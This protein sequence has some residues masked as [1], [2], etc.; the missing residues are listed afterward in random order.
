MAS[1]KEWE[2][3][4]RYEQQ[5]RHLVEFLEKLAGVRTAAD[6]QALIYN[7]IPSPGAVGRLQHTNLQF[8]IDTLRQNAPR[9]PGGATAAECAAYLE[10]AERLHDAG[11]LS[12]ALLERARSLRASRS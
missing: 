8:V 6:V 1:K 5:T 9:F 3:Q 7:N 12:T 11:E 10:L 4:R 2:S